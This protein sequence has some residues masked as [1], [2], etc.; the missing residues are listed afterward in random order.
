VVVEPCARDVADSELWV[1]KFSF[2]PV[3]LHAYRL[4]SRYVNS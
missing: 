1:F 2:N 3:S 4:N